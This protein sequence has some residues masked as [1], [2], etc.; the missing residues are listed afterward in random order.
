M[1][2]MVI[3]VA[4]EILHEYSKTQNYAASNWLHQD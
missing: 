3:R 2:A 1:K 4:A